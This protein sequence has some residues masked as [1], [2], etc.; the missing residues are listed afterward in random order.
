MLNFAFGM[1]LDPENMGRGAHEVGPATLRDWKLAFVGGLATIIPS[2]GNVVY[3]GLWQLDDHEQRMIDQREGYDPNR[4]DNFYDR[5][6]VTVDTED[7]AVEAL[8]YVMTE[9]SVKQRQG[10]WGDYPGRHT[11][12][13]AY[14]GYLIAGYAH[15][16][17]PDEALWDALKETYNA[18]KEVLTHA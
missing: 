4:T 15:F 13:T 8:V 17:L 9:A 5:I 11:P 3:G 12:E 1:N 14:L 16:G 18:P 7:G 2:P 10:R 6:T